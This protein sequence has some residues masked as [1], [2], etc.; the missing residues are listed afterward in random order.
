M[1]IKVYVKLERGDSSFVRVEFYI[2][3]NRYWTYVWLKKSEVLGYDFKTG[4]CRVGEDT[5]NK[6]IAHIK[7]HHTF[8]TARWTARY[9]PERIKWESDT[10]K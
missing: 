5:L 7:E 8:Q 3:G 4:M 2:G 10:D 1:K 6:I 9:Y